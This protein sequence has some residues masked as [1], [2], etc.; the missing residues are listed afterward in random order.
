MRTV[1][2]PATHIREAAIASAHAFAD[3]PAYIAMCPG[4]DRAWRINFMAWLFERNFW[5]RA[6]TSCNR[7][8]FENDQLIAF[9]MFVTPTVPDVGGMDMVRAGLLR[10]PLLFGLGVLMRMLR[11][12][13][14]AEQDNAETEALVRARLGSNGR[15][16]R[17]ERM[18]V[19]P[20]HQGRGIGSKC[21]QHALDQADANGWA[22]VLTTQEERNTRFYQRLGFEVT[23]KTQWSVEHGAGWTLCMRLCEWWTGGTSASAPFAAWSMVRWPTKK[24]S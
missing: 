19:T 21:L 4:R 3:S 20:G 1:V 9:Y 6:G 24:A 17:L 2:L 7:A 15:A 14:V 5:L 12:K 11:I 13:S 23:S 8:V 18:A 22:C 10:I 16:C